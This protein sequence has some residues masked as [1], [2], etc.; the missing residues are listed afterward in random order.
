MPRLKP[1]QWAEL[2]AAYETSERS[3]RELAK[4]YNITEKSIRDKAKKEC[5]EKSGNTH[6]IEKKVNAIKE[7]QDTNYAT[8]QLS[9]Q[10]QLAI[11][12]EVGARLRLE[13][14]MD[15][16]GEEIAKKGKK[17][18]KKINAGTPV[19]ANQLKDLSVAYSNIKGKAQPDTQ[20]NI[21]NNNTDV[22]NARNVDEMTDIEVEEELDELIRE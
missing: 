8:T 19:A 13:G 14:Y 15:S 20:V 9:T 11:N 3:N 7:L 4:H 22:S 12:D 6:L 5:W 18:A 17:I 10:H 2:R 16:W 21:Q 1:E